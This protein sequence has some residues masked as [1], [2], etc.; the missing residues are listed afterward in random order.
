MST[1]PNSIDSVREFCQ[2]TGSSEDIARTFLSACN[3][4]LE[5]AVSLYIDDPNG[6]L[7]RSSTDECRS[8]I[9]QRNEQLL[10]IDVP[11]HFARV[12]NSHP[13]RTHRRAFVADDSGSSSED[14]L[15]IGT[16][17]KT[18]GGHNNPS[19]NKS[20][21]QS[22]NDPALPDRANQLYPSTVG[23]CSSD[24]TQISLESLNGAKNRAPRKR[25]HLQQLYRPPVELLFNGTLSAAHHSARQKDQWI[26]VSLH[27]EGCF[28]CHLLNRDVW[29]D[30]NVF[31]LIKHNFTFLQIPVD[32]PEGLRYRSRYSYVQSA[33]H[34]AILDAL[35]GEQ[36]IM[37]THLKDPDTVNEVL[38]EFLKHSKPNYVPSSSS[39]HSSWPCAKEQ[40]QNG[41]ND[42]LNSSSNVM[43]TS[44]DS[45]CP[46]KPRLEPSTWIPNAITKNLA[47]TSSVAIALGTSSNPLDLTEEEQFQLAIEASKAEVDKLT[48]NSAEIS[49]G[50]S[51]DTITFNA[52]STV[53]AL[54]NNNDAIILTD[55]DEDEEKDSDKATC[56]PQRRVHGD[57]VLN[58]HDDKDDCILIG[59]DS[60]SISLECSKTTCSIT[61]RRS[62]RSSQSVLKHIDNFALD[63]SSPSSNT[64]LYELPI[65]LDDE[66]A[67]ELLI[68]L[69]D[70][71]KE[72]LRL[73]STLQMKD[74]LKHFESRGFSL[75][76]YEFLRLYP[77][78]C[79]SSLPATTTLHDAGLLKKDTLFI[80]EKF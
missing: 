24:A 8:P 66:P 71:T 54:P 11:L 78:L 74:L 53:G 5:M 64:T 12:G 22:G 9:P 35:S 45:W 80:Q 49:L 75:C 68:R 14:D 44:T 6:A 32:S 15:I 70:G 46:K 63:S 28:E 23:R 36:K 67:I 61:G 16:E 42:V 19:G 13:L 60:E 38:S 7:S 40:S 3:Y 58:E 69:P 72:Q 62:L 48:A 27:D 51:I 77:R 55:D 30:P 26:L 73:F 50:Q 1:I 76:Q 18:N 43:V 47:T 57:A 21:Q 25:K 34:I 39:A 79:L 29:K 37:W 59:M 2:V 41:R 17:V 10:P 20:V 56:S 65:P 31:Q 33:S 4:N 52:T